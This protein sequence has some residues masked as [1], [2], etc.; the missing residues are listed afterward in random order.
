M[1]Y[2]GH[3]A[4]ALD[5]RVPTGMMFVPSTDGVSH[6]PEESSPQRLLVL[7]CQALLYAVLEVQ[8]SQ[9]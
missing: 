2:A 1:S 7:G 9:L 4:S 5:G 6:S 8:L 3:D